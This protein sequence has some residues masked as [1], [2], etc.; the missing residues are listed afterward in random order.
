MKRIESID[1]LFWLLKEP[2]INGA[3]L[4]FLDTCGLSNDVFIKS[5]IATLGRLINVTGSNFKN[6][7][8][9]VTSLGIKSV[10]IV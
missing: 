1:S 6:V 10:Q 7:E 5:K 4:E 3:H 9:V 8:N 2:M